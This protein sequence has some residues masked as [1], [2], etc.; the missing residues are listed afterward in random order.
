MLGN[1]EI[2]KILVV[3]DEASIADTLAVILSTRG[4]SVQVAYAAEKAIEIIAEWPPDLAIVDVMLPGM[5]GIDFSIIIR[6]NYPAC[7]L[8]LF[9]GQP[10][11]SVLL[12]E[13]LKKGYN[14]QVHAKPVHPTFILNA[15]EDLLSS[16][17]EPLADA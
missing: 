10:D 15:V 1:A 5:N 2:R 12:E 14:F 6:T 7:R 16:G 4:Y 17:H 13:A 11:T 9:S 8:L 3:E